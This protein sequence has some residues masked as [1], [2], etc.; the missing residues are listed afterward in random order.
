MTNKTKPSKGLQGRYAAYKVAGR[1]ELN[2]LR[3]IE[4]HLKKNPEDACAKE[5]LKGT[6]KVR[7]K[8]VKKKSW[9]KENIKFFYGKTGSVVQ[10]KSDLKAIAQL[11]KLCKKVQRA[12]AHT[13]PPKS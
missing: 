11:L 12:S 9:A 10:T 3:G 8:P 5:A 7:Q 4:R 13:N 1:L 6:P 2:R